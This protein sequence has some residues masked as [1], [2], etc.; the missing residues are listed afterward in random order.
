MKTIVIAI[1]GYSGTG[2]SSTAREVARQLGYVYV[3]SGAMYRAVTLYM[4]E[5]G[6]D[7]RDEEEV[8]RALEKIELTFALNPSTGRSHIHLNGKDVEKEIRTPNVS[9]LV[10]QI[11]AIPEV[12]RKMVAQQQAYGSQG[13][14]VMDG[15]DIATVVFPRAE[16]KIFMIA[17]V[18]ERARRREKE[19]N[20]A[21]ILADYK[22][23]L[24]NLNERDRLDTSREDSPLQMASDAIELD[25]TSITF[26]QQVHQIVGMARKRI[27]C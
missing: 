20:E 23:I 27:G 15:R 4:G 19:L 6:I 26:D 12:R 22:S 11:A 3:D 2:K 21:G 1:D 13:G 16:L 24:A 14:I 17:D 18:A 25:T 5:N 8:K 10:S 9:Q 7:I